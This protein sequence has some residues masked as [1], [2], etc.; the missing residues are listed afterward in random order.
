MEKSKTKI[1][2]ID[3]L[4]Q[5]NDSRIFNLQRHFNEV[6]LKKTPEEGV[7]FVVEHQT[8]R[9]IVV[10]D[11]DFGKND[12]NGLWVLDKIRSK[13]FIIPIILMTESEKNIPQSEFPD[14]INDR[15]FAFADKSSY[16]DLVD[17][18]KAADIELGTRIESALEDWINKHSPEDKDKPY[19]T[20]RDGT[21][22]K[23][24]DI[25]REIRLQT[26]FGQRMELKIINLAIELLARDIKKLP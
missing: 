21:T 11:Y 24:N 5:E 20:M 6:V 23:L 2:V 13:N 9:L 10:L 8:D 1:V 22:Y 19:L 7:D 18:V 25:L 3:D 4:L 12:H 17:K 15:I 26:E 16:K 14:F